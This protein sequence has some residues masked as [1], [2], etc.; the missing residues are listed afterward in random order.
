MIRGF[1]AE[2]KDLIEYILDKATLIS[3]KVGCKNMK[4]AAVAKASGISET[5]LSRYFTMKELKKQVVTL[6]V[7]QR[8]FKLLAHIV[9]DDSTH[10]K[11]P[12]AVRAA[13]VKHAGGK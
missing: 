6:A 5:L 4:R 11:I 10:Y 13:A 3:R 8:D 9:N 7:A 2:S 1:L 12:R